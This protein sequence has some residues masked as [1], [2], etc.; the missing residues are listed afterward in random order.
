MAAAEAQRQNTCLGSKTLEVVDSI[1]AGR[2][3]FFFSYPQY[4][5]L[6]QVSQGGAAL[7]FFLLKQ[8]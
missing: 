4:C 3:A 2:W 6:T 7:L 5:V 8:K 1:P